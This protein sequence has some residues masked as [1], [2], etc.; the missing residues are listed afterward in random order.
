MV[1]HNLYTLCKQIWFT[2]IKQ[3]LKL[4]LP[5]F[6]P[7]I[8]LT[9]PAKYGQKGRKWRINHMKSEISSVTKPT[10][11]KF[12]TSRKMKRGLIGSHHRKPLFFYFCCCYRINLVF[13]TFIYL[14]FYGILW[15]IGFCSN[16]S[17][18]RMRCTYYIEDEGLLI[19][20]LCCFPFHNNF[21][22]YNKWLFIFID[23]LE[24]FIFRID[25]IS[26]DDLSNR[27]LLKENCIYRLAC[28]EIRL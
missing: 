16:Y 7:F 10:A 2:I 18:K 23:F 9:A 12:M 11:H 5:L 3:S 4:Y 8:Q 21:L 6:L 24:I 22:V 14:W 19:P 26:T 17:R 15:L 20:A 28:V 13:S 1:C 27:S 25:A